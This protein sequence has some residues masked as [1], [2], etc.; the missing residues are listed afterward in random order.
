MLGFLL[1]LLAVAL[2][3]RTDSTARTARAHESLVVAQ[4]I[5]RLESGCVT[6][7]GTEVDSLAAA[8]SALVLNPPDQV[9]DSGSVSSDTPYIVLLQAEVDAQLLDLGRRILALPDEPG[10]AQDDVV[11]AFRH[12]YDET[13]SATSDSD[14]RVMQ[15]A[16][17]RLN[18]IDALLRVVENQASRDK[19]QRQDNT[20]SN[21]YSAAATNTPGTAPTAVYHAGTAILDGV[22][23]SRSV[24]D[25]YQ[26][27]VPVEIAFA[28]H[29]R[30]PPSALF[31]DS[32]WYGRLLSP[33]DMQSPF[34]FGDKTPRDVVQLCDG[35]TSSV[36][37]RS[38]FVHLRRSYVA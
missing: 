19:W 8:E 37:C 15:R 24:G 31:L 11:D 10:P 33:D 30:G 12:L 20:P 32:V 28:T 27:V 29:R 38:H 13:H 5:T 18:D 23:D 17:W 7:H 25:S 16:L 4:A 36:L 2:V 35:K 26:F 22:L 34:I 14:L 21:T 6:C 9:D 3:V 1:L